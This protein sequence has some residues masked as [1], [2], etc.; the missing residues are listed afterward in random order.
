MF[1]IFHTIFNGIICSS[2]G[3]CSVESNDEMKFTNWEINIFSLEGECV[4]IDTS[5]GQ[6][7]AIGCNELRAVVCQKGNYVLKTPFSDFV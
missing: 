2:Y 6:W 3:M 7:K 5:S 1:I 4:S